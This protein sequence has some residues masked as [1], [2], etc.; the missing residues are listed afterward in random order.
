M[1]MNMCQVYVC[2]SQDVLSTVSYSGR[3]VDNI[4]VQFRKT[5]AKPLPED[6]N[7]SDVEL[8]INDPEN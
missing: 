1:K 6:V 2:V 3:L 7:S 5:L 4:T 8:F